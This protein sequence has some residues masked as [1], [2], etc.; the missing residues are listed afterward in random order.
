M[1]VRGYEQLSTV[2][3]DTWNPVKSRFSGH[4]P[5]E[6]LAPSAFCQNRGF[7]SKTE[8]WRSTRGTSQAIADT[9]DIISVASANVNEV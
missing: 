6:I 1:V 4:S 8:R 7:E 5:S 2:L 9:V 3:P